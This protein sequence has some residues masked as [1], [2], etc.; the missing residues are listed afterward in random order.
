M[1]SEQIDIMIEMLILGQSGVG[2]TNL[3][4]RYVNDTFSESFKPTIV[5]DYFKIQKSFKGYE[6]IVKFWDTAGQER[7]NALTISFFK[8]ADAIVFVYDTSNRES[9]AKVSYWLD[10]IKTNCQKPVSLMLVGNKTDLLDDKQI[11]TD[12]ASDYA[13]QHNMLFFEASAKCNEDKA[14]HSAFD[15]LIEEKSK[16]MYKTA[17]KDQQQEMRRIRKSLT[18]I[19]EVK[20]EQ[21]D[22]CCN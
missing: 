17:V 13:M 7:F 15:R 5:N 12:E 14:V 10:Q 20:Q 6:A 22:S 1:A 18:H 16:I 8:N 3:V 9:F 19:T 4:Q 11:S 2:K 21:K